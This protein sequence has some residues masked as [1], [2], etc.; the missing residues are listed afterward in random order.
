MGV[1]SNFFNRILRKQAAPQAVNQSVRH[2][3]RNEQGRD[4]VVGDVHGMFAPLE[5]LLKDVSFDTNVDRLFSLGDL[6]DRGLE[7]DKA[8]EWWD[9]TWFYPILGNHEDMLM[10]RQKCAHVWHSNG[11]QWWVAVNQADHGEYD[12]RVARLP[13]AIEVETDDG[14]VG[15]VH[16]DV[17]GNCWRTF[18]QAL[19]NKDHT[20]T[21]TAL[22]SRKRIDQYQRGVTP[23]LVSEVNHV[24]LG[25]TIVEDRTT[26]ENVSY[27]DTGACFYQNERAKLTMMQIH[28][29][30]E[31]FQK[32]T[33][34]K[35]VLKA[36]PN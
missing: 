12:K 13:L 31:K 11:G 9:Y 25:H 20:S 28:P 30:V 10:H 17:L 15:L 22:W 33:Y 18:Y 27:I 19:A 4:F 24:Y 23:S 26:F 2:F 1:L 32:S 6:I 34:L 3:E 21:Q 35:D 14:L 5:V 16:A 29:H 36:M 8:L 7:S